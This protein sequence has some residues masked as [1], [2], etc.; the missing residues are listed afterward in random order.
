MGKVDLVQLK[1]PAYDNACWTKMMAVV[2]DIK[3]NGP[4]VYKKTC[5]SAYVDNVFKQ[6]LQRLN[7]QMILQTSRS[8]ILLK[9]IQCQQLKLIRH[10]VSI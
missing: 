5:A 7:L 3:A 2:E 10:L 4:D 1:E 9:S 8:L 6:N